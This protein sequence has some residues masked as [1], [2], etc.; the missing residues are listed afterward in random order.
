MGNE[1]ILDVGGRVSEWVVTLPSSRSA[2]KKAQEEQESLPACLFLCV[3]LKCKSYNL[4]NVVH[5]PHTQAD[6]RRV[7]ARMGKRAWERLQQLERRRGK[8]R[9]LGEGGREKD[10]QQCCP[11]LPA[12][13]PAPPPVPHVPS[14]D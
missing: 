7:C 9:E 1:N 5:V 6:E 10:D 2:K 8:K 3:P 13:A 4:A 14:A 12:P 11:S